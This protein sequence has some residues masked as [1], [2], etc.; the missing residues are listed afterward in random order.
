MEKNIHIKTIYEL[1]NKI[2]SNDYFSDLI[3]DKFIKRV[4]IINKDINIYI[5]IPPT[6]MQKKQK[7]EAEINDSIKERN[8]E[9]EKININFETKNTISKK[10]PLSNIKNIIVV[11]SGKGGVGKSTVCVNIATH[12]G[13]I[14]Y[15]VGVLDSDIYGPSIPTMLDIEDK[16]LNVT[17]DGNEVKICPIEN[18]NLKV[19]SIGFFIDT[20]QPVIWRG[21]MANK[22]IKQMIYDTNWGDLDF[23]LV[24][25]PPGTGDIHLSIIELLKVT[26]AIIVSTPQ[27][28][29]LIDTQKAVSM[30]NNDNIK[31]P[32]LGIIENMSYFLSENNKKHF[33][34]DKDGAEILAEDLNINFLGKVPLIQK[35]RERSDV[36]RP[37]SLDSSNKIFEP[38][39][40]NIIKE[41]KK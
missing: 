18:Y 4:E 36:G 27:K 38:I 22:A 32:I 28:I 21:A 3:S 5:E 35:I 1:L 33:I 16:K 29:A 11:A 26:G 40:N 37:I 39:I 34:F 25:L 19:L 14:G 20:S 7:L 17:K 31:I 23:L 6:S 8:I 10:D 2:K 41:L 12:L 30:F 9:H 15:K 24:D 13:R